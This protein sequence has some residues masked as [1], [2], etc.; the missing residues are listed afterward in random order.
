MKLYRPTYYKD[1]RCIASACGDNC[2]IGWEI[3]I[4]DKTAAFYRGIGGDFGCRLK[5]NILRDENGSQFIL[6]EDERCPFL[7]ENN[8]CDIY[9]H[10]GESALCE[11]CTQHPRYHEWFGERKESGVG[12]CCEA[13]GRLIFSL[14]KTEF[15]TVDIDEEFSDD[16]NE[17]AFS[18]LL[19]AR[20][21][22]IALMQNRVLPFG[23][24]LLLLLNLGEEVQ[25]ALD[26]EDFDGIHS[27]AAD[28]KDSGFLTEQNFPVISGGESAA[29]QLL[30]YLS[31]LEPID[32]QWPSRLKNMISRLPQLLESQTK[33]FSDNY[34]KDMEQL[35][36]YLLFRYFCKALFDGDVRSKTMLTAVGC[37]VV[38]L[39]DAHTWQESDRF[40]L[41]ERVQNAKA[42]SKEI[43]YCTENLDALC[44]G[45]WSG[46]SL[47][48]PQ[49]CALAALLF[50]Y[51]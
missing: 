50:P 44:D 9:I 25:Q 20:E 11:I 5:Q 15:E 46:E 2:C 21:T 45:F 43:E 48:Y 16:I 10:L 33:L 22:A 6:K 49:L 24:R 18:A 23:K 32:P 41:K 31:T 29:E 12:L 30:S 28:Y 37:C 4:D 7:N 36:V 17:E 13:A 27:I 14:D 26:F 8:L 38:S 3:D 47:S 1:F 51:L 39:L 42:F 40:S 35:A 34:F 19:A